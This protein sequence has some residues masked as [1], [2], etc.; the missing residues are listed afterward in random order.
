[1]DWNEVWFLIPSLLLLIALD[2]TLG[3]AIA[4][5]DSDERLAKEMV[6]GSRYKVAAHVFTQRP[7]L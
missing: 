4:S 3:S 6:Q 7:R 1:M 2:D 5:Q